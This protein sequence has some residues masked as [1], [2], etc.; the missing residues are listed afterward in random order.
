MRLPDWLRNEDPYAEAPAEE[1]DADFDIPDEINRRLNRRSTAPLLRE[2]RNFGKGPPGIHRDD[3]YW[4]ILRDRRGRVIGGAR[5]ITD[6]DPV[7][8]D[9]EVD[10]QHRRQGHATR[11]F[12]EIEAAGYDVESGS[13]HSLATGML[14]PLGYAFHVARRAKTPRATKTTLEGLTDPTNSGSS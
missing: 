2:L 14:S 7:L 13:D 4:W 12:A 10:R 5:V 8:I 9:I 6:E 3:D 1:P 11:L